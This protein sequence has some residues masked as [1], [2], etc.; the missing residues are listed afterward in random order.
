MALFSLK[1]DTEEKKKAPSEVVV[2][3]ETKS[4]TNKVSAPTTTFSTKDI[5]GVLLH[6]RVTEKATVLSER[7][8]YTFDVAPRATSKDIVLAL[9]KVY[10]VVPVKVNIVTIPSKKVR[11][12]SKNTFGVKPGGKKAYVY[13]K[14]GEVIDTV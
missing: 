3:S 6:P 9:K 8:I 11:V 12:R 5:S 10:G 14:K 1:K 4:E 7:N 2:V 13:L